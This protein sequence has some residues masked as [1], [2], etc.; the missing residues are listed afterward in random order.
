VLTE[1]CSSTEW[2]RTAS[3][4]RQRLDFDTYTRAQVLFHDPKAVGDSDTRV[5]ARFCDVFHVD[6]PGKRTPRI[7]AAT[8]GLGPEF[9][10]EPAAGAVVSANKVH[11]DVCRHILVSVPGW[12]EYLRKLEKLRVHLQQ[13]IAW[14]QSTS[15]RVFGV[16]SGQH[17]V[18]ALDTSGSM[19]N[20][21]PFL[22][23]QFARLVREQ[24]RLRVAT[25][26]VVQ[27]ASEAQAWTECLIDVTD[28]SC[29]GAVAW[30]QSLTALGGTN[31]CA[32]VQLA[33]ADEHA[34]TVYILSDGQPDESTREVLDRLTLVWKTPLFLF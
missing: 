19:F 16:V 13:R 1:I 31:V 30:V 25:F 32:A 17:V 3:L 24:V 6:L 21:L 11:T 27:F 28:E 20:S 7:T 12:I 22:Q 26:N 23:R 10:V 9:A 29:N 15:R 33:L 2:L 34:D 4:R 18:F 5:G 14:L 8:L